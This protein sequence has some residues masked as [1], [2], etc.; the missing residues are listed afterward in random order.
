MPMEDWQHW[1]VETAEGGHAT[2]TLDALAPVSSDAWLAPDR[3]R[4]KRL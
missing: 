1:T 2:V 3:P 4:G